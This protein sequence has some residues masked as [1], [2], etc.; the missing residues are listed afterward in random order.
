MEIISQYRS[1]EEL[2]SEVSQH[3]VEWVAYMLWSLE[4]SMFSEEEIVEEIQKI[5]Q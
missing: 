5:L 1:I 4:F 2:R 3:G